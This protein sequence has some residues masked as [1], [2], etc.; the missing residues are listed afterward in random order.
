MWPPP[1]HPWYVYTVIPKP[2]KMHHIHPFLP[3]GFSDCLRTLFKWAFRHQPCSQPRLFPLSHLFT[4]NQS[5]YPVKSFFFFFC[6]FLFRSISLSL[7]LLLLHLPRLW[8]SQ[9][10]WYRCDVKPKN[11]PFYIQVCSV[12]ESS[13]PLTYTM[14]PL[15][16]DLPLSNLSLFRITNMIMTFTCSKIFRVS[17]IFTGLKDPV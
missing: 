13:E 6:I 7:L 8:S 11:L 10:L 17:L 15:L 4:S 1:Q 12:A 2:L 16:P 5:S 14:V 3:L 9:T